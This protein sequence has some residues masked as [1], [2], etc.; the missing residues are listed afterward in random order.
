MLSISRQTTLKAYFINITC[1]LCLWG[2]GEG[3]SSLWARSVA[4]CRQLFREREMC[5]M[6]HFRCTNHIQGLWAGTEAE[7]AQAIN[8]WHE[9]K[10]MMMKVSPAHLPYFVVYFLSGSFCQLWKRQEE[11]KP[12]EIP[13]SSWK[14]CHSRHILPCGKLL[15]EL[16]LPGCNSSWTASV[17]CSALTCTYRT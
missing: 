3:R 1:A 14:A 15:Q 9:S 11:C 16:C 8:I 10:T 12:A 7:E 13:G 6:Q 17:P 5:I 2:G 4:H